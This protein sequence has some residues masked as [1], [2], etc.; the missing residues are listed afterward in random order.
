MVLKFENIKLKMLDFCLKFL[1]I[2]ILTIVLGSH[3]YCQNNQ[4]K[5][6]RFA[7]S[8][9][10]FTEVNIN[11]AKAVT[12]LL[13]QK[14]ISKRE[15]SIRDELIKHNIDPLK[16]ETQLISNISHIIEL[17]QKKE[18]D[19]VIL[20][21]VDY[22]TIKDLNLVEPLFLSGN[23]GIY[24]FKFF[25]VVN[26][27]SKI[28]SFKDLKDKSIVHSS[29]YSSLLNSWVYTK[30]SEQKID[31]F[32]N[33]FTFKEQMNKSSQLMIRLLLNQT[34]ACIIDEDGYNI[35]VE[36][37]SQLNNKLKVIDSSS[38][39]PRGIICIRKNYESELLK[40]NIIDVMAKLDKD[41]DG[42]QILKLFNV[43]GLI[44]FKEEYLI[45]LNILMNKISKIESNTAK[46]KTKKNKKSKGD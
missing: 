5:F 37:N 4:N 17:L 45:N 19:I 25:L 33:Y 29:K 23:N 41:K 14:L 7:Y 22:Y 40:N 6:L 36:L 8:S 30:I 44:K 24:S 9:E 10:L 28:S 38:T 13:L 42:R 27:D 39:F 32:E 43:N 3:S 1:M 18:L 20:S 26:K 15:V 31:S 21:A 12:N 46:T 35:S 34:D 11:D 16:S 2:L